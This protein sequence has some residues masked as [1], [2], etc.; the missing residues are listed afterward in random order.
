M[1]YFG[2]SGFFSLIRIV[3][4]NLTELVTKSTK[5]Q[6]L[7]LSGCRFLVG[8]KVCSHVTTVSHS[9]ADVVLLPCYTMAIRFL[10]SL[11]GKDAQ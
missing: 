10:I 4:E 2:L 3:Q 6:Q 8:K 5:Y 9:T 7:A 1:N 11:S